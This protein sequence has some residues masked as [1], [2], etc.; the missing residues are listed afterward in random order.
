MDTST[1]TLILA[2]Q[3]MS[4]TA[5]ELEAVDV[6]KGASSGGGPK[7][8]VLKGSIWIQTWMLLWKNF[9][10]K[11]KRPLS[12]FCELALPLLIV[13]LLSWVRSL[14]D[15]QPKSYDIGENLTLSSEN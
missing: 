8:S 3:V 1:F 5:I 6:I 7:R 15:L 13:L 9:S 10:L 11:K 14:N 12:T 2:N 4:S